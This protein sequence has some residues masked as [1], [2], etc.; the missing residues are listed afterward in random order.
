MGRLRH[1]HD[2]IRSPGRHAQ[3]KTMPETLIEGVVFGKLVPG[4]IVHRDDAAGC[5]QQG[6]GGHWGVKQIGS[7]LQEQREGVPRPPPRAPP[8]PPA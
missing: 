4:E 2:P 7:L 5:A 8:D 6:E 3:P 1:G